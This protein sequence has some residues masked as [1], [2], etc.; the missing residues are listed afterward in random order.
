MVQLFR[1]WL[2]GCVWPVRSDEIVWEP[3]WR[4]SKC[5]LPCREFLGAMSRL[6]L[7]RFLCGEGGGRGGEGGRQ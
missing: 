3:C 2:A 1:R 6:F 4:L 7:S 5:L